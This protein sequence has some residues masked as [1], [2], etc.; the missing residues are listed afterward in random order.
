MSLG[1]RV[2]RIVAMQ[3]KPEIVESTTFVDHWLSILGQSQLILLSAILHTKLYSMVLQGVPYAARTCSR[4]PEDR[5]KR[6][7]ILSVYGKTWC[8]YIRLLW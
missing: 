3:Q 5:E 7:F 8:R 2:E 4:G 1:L 6:V